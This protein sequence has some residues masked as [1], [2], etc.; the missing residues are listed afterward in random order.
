MASKIGMAGVMGLAKAVRLAVRP[1]GPTLGERAGAVPR[2]VRA[3]MRGEYHG[4]TVGRLLMVAAAA[5]YL[6]SPVDLL[7]EALLGPLGLADDA[8][9]LSWLATQ[10]VQETED[11]LTWEKDAGPAAAPSG[12]G[13]GTRTGTEPPTSSGSEPGPAKPASATTVPGHVVR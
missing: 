12:A 3:T 11:F 9:V 1:G 4:I 7:P 5:G 13:T 10:L 2:L 8:M 6:V